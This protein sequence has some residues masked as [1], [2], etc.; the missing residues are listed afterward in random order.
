[1]SDPHELLGKIV[2]HLRHGGFSNVEICGLIKGTTP[3]QIELAFQ[4][5][6]KRCPKLCRDTCDACPYCVATNLLAA[7]ALKGGL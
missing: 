1:M 7:K 5:A 3:M 4:Q 2:Q 6:E